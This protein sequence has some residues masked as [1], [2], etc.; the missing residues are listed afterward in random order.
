MDIP[1]LRRRPEDILALARQ[2]LE[3][4]SK[5]KAK[6]FCRLAPETEK[7]LLAYSWP[8]N[9]RELRS[10]IEW[11]VFMHDELELKP[12]HLPTGLSGLAEPSADMT[13]F[14]TI[15]LPAQAFPLDAHI[16]RIVAAAL[17]NHHGNKKKTAEYLQISRRSLYTY[18]EHIEAAEKSK[19]NEQE[20]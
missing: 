16:R 8:G 15:A 3:R 2:Y 5:N 4:L 18:L 13:E 9:V 19:A 14:A 7:L 6:R 12:R 11:A 1:P 10:S 17:K 20:S